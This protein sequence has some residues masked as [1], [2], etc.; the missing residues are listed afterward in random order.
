MA[1]SFTC[2]HR[3]DSGQA[4]GSRLRPPSLSK[5]T[6][7]LIASW[8]L[9]TL[10]FVA[11]WCGISLL[12]SYG[13]WRTLADA[14]PGDAS[15]EGTAFRFQSARI[16][17]VNY[18]RSLNVI[19]SPSKLHL[20]PFSFFRVGHSPIAI[21]WSHISAEVGQSGFQDVGILRVAKHPRVLVRV[22]RHLL[23]DMAAASHGQL[24]VEPQLAD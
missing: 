17:I 7:G 20:V 22:P 10:F 24:H 4:R 18:N 12:L 2:E 23:D 9:F 1:R 13:G 6:R 5:E 3:H 16:G 11:L 15:V 8:L 14:Y 19:A 21:P